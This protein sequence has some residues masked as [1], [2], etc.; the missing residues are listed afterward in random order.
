[1]VRHNR[2]DENILQAIRDALLPLRDDQRL[3]V[4]S[5]YQK[6][7]AVFVRPSEIRFMKRHY[8]KIKVVTDSENIIWMK[9]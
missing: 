1:M 2:S 4:S 8:N 6:H 5:S 9:D 3:E 7:S